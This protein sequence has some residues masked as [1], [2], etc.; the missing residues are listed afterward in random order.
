MTYPAT[1]A[2]TAIG[3]SVTFAVTGAP[4][5]PNLFGPGSVIPARV[6]ITCRTDNHPRQASITAYVDG[7]WRKDGNAT[8]HPLGQH[9]NG[10]VNTW[11]DWLAGIAKQVTTTEET[12]R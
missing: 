12:T 9:F 6:E 5:V 11:P 3:H 7:H 10:P 4:D 1:F 8:N 2:L